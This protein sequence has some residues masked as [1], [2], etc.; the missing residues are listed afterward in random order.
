MLDDAGSVPDDAVD[1]RALGD[2]DLDHL[3]DVL[4]ER[5]A[6]EMRRLDDELV[7]NQLDF[8][9]A[10]CPPELAAWIDRR[11]PLP[12]WTDREL[13]QR[14]SRFADQWLPELVISYLVASLPT[15]YAGAKGVQVL[16][17]ASLLTA[18]EPLLRRLLETLLLA[19]R[20]YEPGALE[21]GGA[22]YE[23]VR[24]V[25]VFHAVIRLLVEDFAFDRRAAHQRGEPW[26]TGVNG[27][28]VNQEDLLGTLWTFALTPLEALERGG[29][30]LRRT[31]KDAVVHLWCVVGHLIGIGS[32][33]TAPVLPMD[34]AAAKAS[35]D[36][37]RHRELRGTEEGRELLG[38]LIRRCRALIPIPL[39]R[40]LPAAAIRQNL[41]P[42]LADELLVPTAWASRLMLEIARPVV[43][44]STSVP[45]ASA[46]RAPLSDLLKRFALR[47]LAEERGADRL[48]A[49][50][51]P[52]QRRRLEPV[53]VRPSL[54][55]AAHRPPA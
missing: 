40:G 35:W 29:A 47:W 42:A 46:L 33:S 30:R 28:A 12:D 39:L 3:L 19:I 1:L 44:A 16:S 48:P 6:A 5:S 24:R 43:F 9:I 27:R 51:A 10:E 7:R 52:S 4:R 14:A 31:D 11:V 23:L 20:V 55:R 50:L 36:D 8:S 53:R 41:G 32:G 26:P 13:L 38:V 18:P 2:P 21:V 37:I 49:D 45:G 17:R 22:G 34:F 15:A 54:R 25:R